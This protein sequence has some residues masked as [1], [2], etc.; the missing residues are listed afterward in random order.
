MF[1]LK[2]ARPYRHEAP[3]VLKTVFHFPVF[4]FI[5]L[6]SKTKECVEASCVS[7]ANSS[8][9]SSYSAQLWAK[10]SVLAPH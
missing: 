9:R 3:E 6:A 10:A 7:P 1:L 8:F 4:S 5:V 2:F